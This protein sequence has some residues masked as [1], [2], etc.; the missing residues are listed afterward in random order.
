MA[1]PPFP[2]SAVAKVVISPATAQTPIPVYDINRFSHRAA[3]HVYRPVCRGRT[4]YEMFPFTED[5]P[6]FIAEF[7]IPRRI[8]FLHYLLD[9]LP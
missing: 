7:V 2:S 4:V 3:H 1:M 8:G 9:E 6:D 5:S